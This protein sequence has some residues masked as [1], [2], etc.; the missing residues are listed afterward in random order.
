VALGVDRFVGLKNENYRNLVICGV[1]SSVF[2]FILAYFT[3]LKF[4]VPIRRISDAV[5]AI[6]AGDHS[7]KISESDSPELTAL[8]ETFNRMSQTLQ[9]RDSVIISQSAELKTVNDMLERSAFERDVQ[10]DAESTV[11]RIIIK[12]LV[13]GLL[14]ADDRQMFIEINPAAEKM[15]GIK[16]SDLIG[17]PVSKLYDSPGLSEL[18]KLITGGAEGDSPEQESVLTMKYKNRNLRFTLIHVKSE[19]EFFRG[20]LLGICDVTADGEV[21]RLKSGFISKVSH[22]LKTPLTSMKGSLQFILKKGKWLT[23]VER[24]MLTVCFRNTERLI[25]LVAGI[26]ELSRIES[27]QINFNMRPLQMGEVV[28]YA[29]EETKG[30]ALLRN[31]SLINDVPM[32]LPKIYGDYQRLMQVVSNLLS[33]AIKFSPENS[34]VTLQAA[35]ENSFMTIFIADNGNVI[36]EEERFSLFSRFQQ[37][38]RPE[39]GEFSGSGL[40]LAICREIIEKHGGSIFHEPGTDGGNI[41]AFKVPL[42]GA[43]DD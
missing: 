43:F 38:G 25:G 4:V 41:F 26:I 28:L 19:K 33:N 40:G 5:K 35:V 24:E 31:T 6:E 34:I 37:M 1:F 23:G 10:K 27:G 14:V 16:A 36:P 21:D 13:D 11:Q 29:I 30:A 20:F 7:V 22:E 9:E 18:T 12:S 15:L 32:D 17:G 8:S 42:N 3:A 39:D 2:I